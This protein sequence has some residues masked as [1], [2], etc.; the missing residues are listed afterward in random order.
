MTFT[1]SLVFVSL[2]L[3]LAVVFGCSGG[4]SPVAP[5]QQ[6]GSLDN[7][8][9]IGLSETENAFDAVGLLGAYELTIDPANMTAEINSKRIS[10]IGEDYLVSGK[11]FFTVTPCSDCLKL[12]GITITPDGN[13]QLIFS[14]R[15]P[16]A[17]GNPANPPSAINRLDLDVFD[18]AMVVAPKEANKS[19][20]PLTAKDVYSGLT[21]GQDGYTTELANVITG[22][23]AA[24][25]F[26]LVID[27]SV[28]GTG[29]WN[30]FGMGATANFDV[31]FSLTAGVLK[32]DTY[33]T[34]GYGASAKK[35]QRLTPTY[36]NPEFNRKNAWKVVVTPPQGTNPPAIG[37]TWQDN[38]ATTTFN[39][40]VEVY[41]W[42][43]GAT[44]DA[45][46]ATPTA[47]YAASN[48]ASVSAEIAGMNTVLPSV[49]TDDGT[50]T[51]MQDAP[52]VFLVPV[53]NQNL[54][55]P[56]TY[57]GLVKVTDSRLPM[58]PADGRD[59]LI[60]TPD[61]VALNNYTIPEYATYQTFTATVVQGCGP[62]EFVS[63]TG[64]PAADIDN[65]STVPFVIT[66]SSPLGGEP[67]TYEIDTDYD[68][69]FD[70]DPA[71]PAN[72][73]GVFN[74]LFEDNPCTAGTDYVIAFRMTDQ[75][76]PANTLVV[77]DQCTVTIGVCCPQVTITS[78]SPN[79]GYYNNQ[80]TIDVYGTG[81]TAGALLEARFI[82]AQGYCPDWISPTVSVISSTHMQVWL[83]NI[84]G[85]GGSGRYCP[86]CS[87]YYHLKITNGCGNSFQLDNAFYQTCS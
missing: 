61:G 70:A 33:L 4:N 16:F 18:L 67:I 87:V 24:L 21:Y 59:F 26:F 40:K 8:P 47:V 19:N 65:G 5:N 29:T 13:G 23:S 54:L 39:V 35:A 62:L 20:F 80:F 69:T 14:I 64:C 3:L 81:F 75:C 42:Q 45:T 7:A 78:L 49:T 46:L 77:A 73:T 84:W 71:Y 58:T 25:P 57:P 52:L 53:A 76:D 30:K 56:G 38:D 28:S 50:G 10:A 12:V 6:T 17:P 43:I 83:D 11:G 51:G 27:D 22:E 44:E 41:D 48:V 15:H 72:T 9:I 85:S 82:M 2:V 1:R 66:G 74:V 68:G 86:Y 32:F 55:V 31:G 34:M 36:Y 63:L 37:N 79:Q 60:D